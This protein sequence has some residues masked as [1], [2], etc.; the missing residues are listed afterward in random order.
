MAKGL[1]QRKMKWK[2][3]PVIIAGVVLSLTL[4][5]F[6]GRWFWLLALV[7]HFRI[8]YLV[9]LASAVIPAC[10]WR[11]KK[12]MGLLLVLIA[13]QAGLME[14]WAWN[15]VSDAPSNSASY[16]LIW[17]NVHTGN[18]SKSEVLDYL[19][20]RDPDFICLGEVNRLWLQQ[21]TPLHER[22]PHQVLQPRDDNFGMAVYSKYP[23]KDRFKLDWDVPCI[24]FD[25]EHDMN[26]T[27]SV[28]VAHPV[29]PIG[30]RFTGLRDD[31][32][33]Q[34]SETMSETRHPFVAVG[35]FNATPWHYPVRE[36]V[37]RHQLSYCPPTSMLSLPT[38]PIGLLPFGIPIDLFLAQP[39]ISI[40][41]L[42]RGPDLGSDHRPLEVRFS[43]H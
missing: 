9:L 40:H 38:W 39:A 19:K 17:F 24:R 15:S 22:W 5:A 1:L 16:S 34:V 14:P 8:H 25:V 29:P 33:R 41:A 10:W 20:E 18:R 3:Y 21:L 27:F 42:N 26:K 30:N 11:Q 13:W 7:D 36:M 12:T 6:A 28:F 31:Y 37:K 32:L 23:F 2:D 43:Q 35:D 4:M